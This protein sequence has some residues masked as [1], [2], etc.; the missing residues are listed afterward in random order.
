VQRFVSKKKEKRPCVPLSTPSGERER[1]KGRQ[2]LCCGGE[3]KKKRRKKVRSFRL[4]RLL[5]SAPIGGK[6]KKKK[7]R[8]G[9]GGGIDRTSVLYLSSSKPRW[10]KRKG[11]KEEN[12]CHKLPHIRMFLLPP[13]RGHA[14]EG[15]GKK[16]R[17]RKKSS[18]HAPTGR[19]YVSFFGCKRLGKKKEKK[20]K[21]K[22]GV[23]EMRD[24]HSP[25]PPPQFGCVGRRGEKGRKKR[26][27]EKG[28]SRS[29]KKGRE[30]KGGEKQRWSATTSF[31]PF[32]NVR[33]GPRRD[34]TRGRGEEERK[35]GSRSILSIGVRRG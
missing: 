2:G 8:R 14:T 31:L 30:K 5:L 26:R 1:G 25:C 35:G 24:K 18:Y 21:G 16:K 27:K 17:R 10:K 28:R 34:V 20:R 19:R 22:R 7:R 9:G 3:K 4:S 29:G 13:S 11:G 15:E 33:Y 32:Q 23:E 12:T 6:K